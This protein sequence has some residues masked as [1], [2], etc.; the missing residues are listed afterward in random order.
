M[1]V[2][3]PIGSVSACLP[4]CYPS[5]TNAR[6]SGPP[7]DLQ[8][9]VGQA[10]RVRDR[11]ASMAP[12]VRSRAGA[13]DRGSGWVSLGRRRSIASAIGVVLTLVASYLVLPVSP[14]AA[15]PGI[16][17]TKSAPGTVRAGA[18]IT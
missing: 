7:A 9:R 18:P 15:A 5:V 16:T 13:G 3:L 8:R 10:L 17:L 14:A 11:A 1:A 6:G 4:V 12:I 2:V